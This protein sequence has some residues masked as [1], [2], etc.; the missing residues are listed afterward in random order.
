MILA[1]KIKKN[2][3]LYLRKAQEKRFEQQVLQEAGKI[4][5]EQTLINKIQGQYNDRDTD[6]KK[7]NKLIRKKEKEARKLETLEAEILKRLRDTHIKQQ[8]AIE[9]IQ[10]I[11]KHK[12]KYRDKKESLANLNKQVTTIED[13]IN[14][15]NQS[16]LL[17]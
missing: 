7:E 13:Q 14:L 15:F 4:R 12:G 16:K 2:E 8:Q 3:R 17:T 1:K 11:F 10:E 6:L 5:F 9:Q